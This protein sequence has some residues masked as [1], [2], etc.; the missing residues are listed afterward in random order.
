MS[1]PCPARTT[2]TDIT[3]IGAF[4]QMRPTSRASGRSVGTKCGRSF[5]IMAGLARESWES[6]GRDASSERYALR[7]G[8]PKPA[9]QHHAT[10]R[11][12]EEEIAEHRRAIDAFIVR[13]RIA[14]IPQKSALRRFVGKLVTT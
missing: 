9:W 14:G 5:D 6:R 12:S 13:L 4:R 1:K 10:Q 8:R 7:V 11:F 2:T 3:S